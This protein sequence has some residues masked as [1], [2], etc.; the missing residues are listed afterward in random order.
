MDYGDTDF[1]GSLTFSNEV[2]FTGL[3]LDV[4]GATL[5][6]NVCEVSTV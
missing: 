2:R 5:F 1:T 6:G 4:S 3:T